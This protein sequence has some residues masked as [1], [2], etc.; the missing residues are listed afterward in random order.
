MTSYKYY[1]DHKDDAEFRK[2][3]SLKESERYRKKNDEFK[4]M[5]Q[6]IAELKSQLISIAA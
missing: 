3:R 6:Q 2:I 4:A 5:K 1:H